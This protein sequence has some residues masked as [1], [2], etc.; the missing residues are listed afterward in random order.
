LGNNPI[1]RV[2]CFLMS[3]FIIIILLLYWLQCWIILFTLQ[4]GFPL[5]ILFLPPQQL[6]C[7]KWGWLCIYIHI[8]RVTWRIWPNRDIR[9]RKGT[10]NVCY[11]WEG[12]SQIA[13]KLP[14]TSLPVYWP[15][16]PKYI[17]KASKKVRTL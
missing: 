17:R 15:Y 9:H 12:L 3:N 5:D 16:V 13:K 7:N 11:A 8:Y 2:I 6:F 14:S 4:S 10:W 1:S